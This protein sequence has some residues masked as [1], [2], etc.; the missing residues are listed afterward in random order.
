MTGASV[1][2]SSPRQATDYGVC[3]YLVLLKEEALVQFQAGAQA[4]Q[5]ASTYVR[6]GQHPQGGKPAL[7][8]R[9]VLEAQHKMGVI[10]SQLHRRCCCTRVAMYH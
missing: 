1:P 5:Q 10:P 9:Q 3:D 8:L 6:A 2:R 7:A 4:V